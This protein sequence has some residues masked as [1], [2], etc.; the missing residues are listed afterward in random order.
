MLK[1]I[2]FTAFCVTSVFGLDSAF[3]GEKAAEKTPASGDSGMDIAVGQD[4]HLKELD[5]AWVQLEHYIPKTHKTDICV[6]GARDQTLVLRISGEDLQVRTYDLKLHLT[7][8]DSNKIDIALEDGYRTHFDMRN[9]DKRGFVAD[10]S[11]AKMKELLK[12]LEKGQKGTITYDTVYRH[13]QKTKK[14]NTTHTD[15]V[16]A[17][18]R[19]C[20]REYH[21]APLE[22]PKPHKKVKKSSSEKIVFPKAGEQGKA[23]IKSK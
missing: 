8:A 16:F 17:A 21:F 13:G 19:D 10:V 9:L 1:K 23:D 3:A 7:P 11:L 22:A 6:A 20:V 15:K 14:V 18:F 5:G 4:L 2:L 12:E